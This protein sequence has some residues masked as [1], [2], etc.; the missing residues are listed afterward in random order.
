RALRTGLRGA[1]AQLPEERL[2][3]LRRV[4]R[5]ALL[6]DVVARARLQ[7][8]VPLGVGRAVE[9]Q[10]VA[11]IAALAQ[12]VDELEDRGAAGPGVLILDPLL[13]TRQQ[14]PV[15]AR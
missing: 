13:E 11:E 1:L 4:P 2:E 9:E 12:P 14:I 10:P 5:A 8:P 3:P 15:D 6:E 7:L